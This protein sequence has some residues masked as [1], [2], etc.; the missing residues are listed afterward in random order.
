MG[1][2]I[3][4]KDNYVWSDN[5]YITKDDVNKKRFARK[6]KRMIQLYAEKYFSVQKRRDTKLRGIL[7]TT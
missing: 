1:Y 4:H 3:T 6:A 7:K 5:Y 2:Y